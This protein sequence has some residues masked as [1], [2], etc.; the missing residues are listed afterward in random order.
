MNEVKE[1]LKSYNEKIKYYVNEYYIK[2]I[3]INVLYIISII[4]VIFS[5]FLNDIVFISIYII[6]FLICYFIFK[7]NSIIYVFPI[8][9]FNIIFELFLKN[10]KY[11]KNYVD[12]LYK[13]AKIIEGNDASNIKA[14]YDNVKDQVENLDEDEIETL[15][16]SF[17]DDNCSIDIS[18]ATL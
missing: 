9:I 16:K 6:L 11:L 18:C 5:F 8:I 7:E 17:N 14:I 13:K 3:N 2:N 1:I 15:S 10:N 12:K 4:Y